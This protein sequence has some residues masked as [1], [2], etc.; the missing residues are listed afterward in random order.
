VKDRKE[1]GAS[2]PVTLQLRC[3]AGKVIQ[4]QQDE[5]EAKRQDQRERKKEKRKRK[6]KGKEG[7]KKQAKCPT[8]TTSD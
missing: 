4:H 3:A 8:S 5:R 7:S 2:T 1:R 6:E